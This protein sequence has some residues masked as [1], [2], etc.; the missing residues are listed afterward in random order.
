MQHP[1]TPRALLPAML[2]LALGL[3]GPAAA[4]GP[5]T[6][7]PDLRTAGWNEIT[8]R[9]RNP[10]EFS[11]DGI[12]GL[13]IH[14]A[15]G[16]SVLWRALPRGFA[17]DRA[18]TWRWRVDRGVPPTDLARR[19]SDDRDIAVYFLFADDPAT[20]DDPPSTLA[21]ALRKGRALVYV[22]G[23]DAPAGAIVESP[24]MRGRGLLLIRRPADSA[25]GEWRT[26]D[27][28]LAGDFRR[29]FGD[30]P[31]PLVGVG[32]STDSDDTGTAIDAAL[33]G[34]VIR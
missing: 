1:R 15:G 6:F 33:Q 14:A 28:D 26:E 8:F 17:G 4:G 31:G 30:T 2:A 18:A 9:G 22:W 23:S 5:V 7:G 34:L 24:Q 19:G 21:G 16:V 13:A 12:D 25:T 11:A 32:V 10:A 3:A 20:L 27:V 29:A